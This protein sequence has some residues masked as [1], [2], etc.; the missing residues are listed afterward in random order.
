[1]L[2]KDTKVYISIAERPGN[3]GST[4]FNTVFKFLGLNSIYKPF[5]VSPSNL[6][7]V[8]TSIRALGISG[9]GVSM[10]HKIKIL[11]YLDK[12]DKVA[13]KIGAINTVVNRKGKLIGY[14][15]D[16]I[17]VERAIAEK[18]CVKNK[19]VLLIGS[20]GIARA[21]V[22]ALIK[23]GAGKIFVASRDKKKSKMLAKMFRLNYCD[24]NYI[25][26]F[27]S[28]LLVNATPVGMV[29]NDKKMIIKKQSVGYYEAVMDVVVSSKKT[30][31]IKTAEKIGKTIITGAQVS[32]YQAAAQFELYTGKKAPINIIKR[33]IK[34]Y[35]N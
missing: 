19:K 13:R 6:G 30:D 9:C 8:V 17:G 20:G 3:F 12:V 11:R 28:D 18:Y 32:M 16:Y 15:T 23:L 4:I 31:L 1:M 35:L 33:C 5:F 24:F 26:S 7:K 2:D 10:P 29:G 22:V 14:N 34:K 25:D 27:H 21:I